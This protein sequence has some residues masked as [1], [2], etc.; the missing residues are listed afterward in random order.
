M[1]IILFCSIQSVRHYLCA[2][3]TATGP[4]TQAAQEHKENTK[5]E[6]T[7]ETTHQKCKTKKTHLRITA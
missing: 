5:I 2:D 7:N 1:I 6:A 3:T 4:I